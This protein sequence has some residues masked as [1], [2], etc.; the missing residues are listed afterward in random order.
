MRQKRVF[1]GHAPWD[2]PQEVRSGEVRKRRT[3]GIRRFALCLRLSDHQILAL[4]YFTKQANI[5]SR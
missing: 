1:D 5:C 2:F 3:G 4:L